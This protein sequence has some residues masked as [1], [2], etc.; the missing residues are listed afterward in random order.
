MFRYRLGYHSM[1]ESDSVELSHDLK[2]S[3]AEISKMVAEAIRVIDPLWREKWNESLDQTDSLRNHEPNFQDLWSGPFI[4][5]EH[6]SV[7]KWL[8]D[9]K[10]FQRV[11][12]EVIWSA[13][14]WANLAEEDNWRDYR[15][16]PDVL[17]QVREALAGTIN[18]RIY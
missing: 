5:E 16:K 4:G 6:L 7:A 12:Y 11:G 14:G 15:D 9:N 2:F 1:E 13:F 3:E 17:D 8:C 18:E 10:G